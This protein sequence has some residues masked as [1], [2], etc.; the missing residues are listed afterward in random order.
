M[1]NNHGLECKNLFDKYERILQSSMFLSGADA[2]S[3]EVASSIPDDAISWCLM[4]TDIPAN[5]SPKTATA[6]GNCLYFSA[7]I[8]LTGTEVLAHVLR[9]LVAAELFLEA[10]FYAGHPYFKENLKKCNYSESTRFAIALSSDYEDVRN[11]RDV[12]VEEAKV[13]CRNGK[14]GAMLQIMALTSG[15][16]RPIFAVYPDTV[17]QAV[18]SFL[19]WSSETKNAAAQRSTIPTRDDLNNVDKDILG[20]SKCRFRAKPLCTTYSIKLSWL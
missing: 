6:D 16:G 3:Y 13:T 19:P 8:A 17:N 7:S 14:W 20:T 4:P 5:L 11:R 9:L 15:I 10:D 18:R 12:V 2:D 1:V